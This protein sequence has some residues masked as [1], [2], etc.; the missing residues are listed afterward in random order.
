MADIAERAGVALSTVSYVLSGKRRISEETRQRVLKAI[1]DLEYRPHAGARALASGTSHAIALLLPKSPTELNIQHHT[2]IAGAAQATGEHGYALQL[3]TAPPQPEHVSDLVDNRQADGVVLMEVDMRDRRVE[4]LRAEGYAFSVIGHCDDSDGISYVDF[5]FA[6]SMQLAV[7]HLVGLG[8][9]R[10]VL[11]DE[12]PRHLRR[13]GPTVRSRE[14]FARLAGELGFDGT[15]V[16]VSLTLTPQGIREVARRTFEEFRP[17]AAVA[18]GLAGAIAATGN[19]EIRV[20]RDM[21]V[22]A[23]LNPQLAQM[24]STPLTTVDFPAFEMG[25]VGAEMLIE[26]LMKPNEPTRQLLIAPPLT[27]REST[28]EAP[29][30]ARR[31]P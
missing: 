13:Y 6:N 28:A 15:P 17:T 25:R 29:H 10:I 8:H 11:F 31:S 24:S 16:N 4:R 30:S 18:I 19:D 12:A 5:D 2:F 14:A 3:S 7:E 9:R 20:P 26:R 27:V 21:S 23:L 1:A 22:V